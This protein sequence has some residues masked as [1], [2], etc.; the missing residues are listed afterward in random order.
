MDKLK[1][2]LMIFPTLF[3]F[4]L[5]FGFTG[6]V[7]MIHGVAIRHI[8]FILTFISLYGYF[9]AY[10]F[11]NNI[12]LYSKKRD[13]YFGGLSKIDVMAIVFEISFILSMTVIPYFMGTNMRYAH[14]EAFDSAAIFSLYFPVSYLIKKGEIHRG[15]WERLIK[16]TIFCYACMCLVLYCGQEY[17]RSTFISDFFNGL[18]RLFGGNGIVQQVILGHGGYTRVM[19]GTSVYLI[20]GIY[21]FLKEE[22][23]RIWDYLIYVVE[24]LAVLAT[25]TKSIWFGMGIAYVVYAV[26]CITEGVL[27]KNR[28]KI[29]QLCLSAFILIGTITI[30][31][32]TLFQNMIGIRMGNAFAV[33]D[34]VDQVKETRQSSDKKKEEKKPAN[35]KKEIDKEGAVISN[36]IKIEQISQ[37]LR[38]W[39]ESPSWGQGYGSYVESYIRSKEA[40]FSY[41]MQFFALLMKIGIVGIAVWLSFFII[42]LISMFRKNGTDWRLFSAWIFMVLAEAIC[43]QTNPLLIS[44][45]GMSMILFI[46]LSTVFNI[47]EVK[48][49]SGDEDKKRN[50]I[51]CDGSI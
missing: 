17:I 39:S 46:S 20:L 45:T 5:I 28:E 26:F 42:Q 33:E 13:S 11:F 24:I 9:I 16:W 32:A 30:S 29:V 7:I 8:L 18:N 25:V 34:N 4:E 1:R 50:R 43:V 2:I 37:L 49:K 23:K 41:E 51:C 40:P 48:D 22:K 14:S 15:N 31:N 47:T 35:T 27:R 38:K 44:F 21:F 12:P 36:Q 3:V 6:T 19:F 10:L